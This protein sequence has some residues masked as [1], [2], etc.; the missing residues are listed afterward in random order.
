MSACRFA[1]L[2]LNSIS[3]LDTVTFNTG[4]RGPGRQLTSPSTVLVSAGKPRGRT[5][6]AFFCSYAGGKG[7]TANQASNEKALHP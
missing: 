6:I 4:L 3:S 2:F 5:H 1:P 7:T